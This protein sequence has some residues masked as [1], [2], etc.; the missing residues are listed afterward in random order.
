MSKA[1]HVEFRGYGFWAYDVVYAVFLKYLI[2]AANEET[3]S[4][5]EGWL[6]EAVSHWRI[7]AAVSDLGVY[8][9]DDWTQEQVDIVIDLCRKAVKAIRS[10]GDIPVYEI[11]SVPICNDLYID[12]RGH[13][14][15]PFEP[16]ARFG[17]AMVGLL[18]ERVPQ[19]PSRHWWFFTLGDDVATIPWKDGYLP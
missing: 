7:N 6:Q 1:S 4:N 3:S 5:A 18:Q 13:D 11:A 15:V 9:N 10:R 16:V 17:D 2:D 8:L 14:P 12:T 19:P